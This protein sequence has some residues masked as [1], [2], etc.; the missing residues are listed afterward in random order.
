[1]T[2]KE[3]QGI[4]HELGFWQGFVKTKRFEGWIANSPTPELPQKVRSFI[5]SLPNN[6]KVMDVGSGVVSILNGMPG[7]NVMPVDPLGGLYELIFDYK[8]HKLTPPAPIPAE[9][10]NFKESFDIVH[11]SNAID[12]TQDPVKSLFNLA[13]AT[14]RGGH[15]IVQGFV[16]EAEHENYAGFHQHNVTVR[17]KHIVI[18]N[19]EI[20]IPHFETVLSEVEINLG[21][22]E[23]FTWIG[24]K[25]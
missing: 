9:E 1:M 3:I 15:L 22:R 11:I 4:A 10:I 21:N 13:D 25:N 7:L 24:R 5:Q 12:H 16:N 14:I 2:Q 8:K 6:L 18:D 20:H 17:E 19:H 23:W